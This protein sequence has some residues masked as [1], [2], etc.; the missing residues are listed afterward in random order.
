LPT[1]GQ[2]FEFTVDRDWRIM[3]ITDA[4][5]AWCGSVP[6]KLVGRDSRVALPPP[7]PTVAAAIEDAFEAGATT[8]LEQ[9]S[10]FAPGRWV[11][12]EVEPTEVGARF[13]FEDITSRVSADG[14]AHR[15]EK[16]GAYSIGV[17]PAEIAILDRRGVIVAANQ[18]WRS[19]VAAQGIDVP[20]AGLG[21]AYADLCKAAIPGLDRDALQQRLEPLLTGRVSMFEAT[22]KLD[23][24]HGRE[25]RQVHITPL[26][27]KS[28]NRFIAIH[29][30]LTERAQI[31]AT[32]DETSDQLLHAQEE[33]RRRIAIE[34]HDS[35]SQHLTGLILGLLNLKRSL[36]D[37]RGAAE[38]ID[39]LAEVAQQ[40]S[41][42]VRVLSFLMNA[43]GSQREGLKESVRRFVEGFGRRTGIEVTFQ[44]RGSIDAI[45]AVAQHAVFRVVQE[46]LSNVYRHAH[47]TAVSV[48]L[49]Q[50]ASVLTARISDN[51]QGFARAAEAPDDTPLLG[52]GIP[53]M[54]ARI[55]QLGGSLQ[56]AADPGGTTLAATLPFRTG[57]P[58]AP[59]RS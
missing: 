15:S 33:E 9:A 25:L 21:M 55:E 39:E 40:A 4:T 16:S 10:H 38:R 43:S 42:E 41:R 54:R 52:V 36:G 31:L 34:L 49:V 56:I 29:E 46:A 14:T 20:S 22:Y 59:R 48:K 32:L 2:V 24:P 19:A 13:R 17:G 57:R 47:A 18:T 35:T 3:T 12:I 6:S 11:R 45:G 1:A 28:A 44:A 51:G 26:Q 23:T 27:D 30:D 8:I 5:A 7:Q 50:E 58:R 53:G 37:D